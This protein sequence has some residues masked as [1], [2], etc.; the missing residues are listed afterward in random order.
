[1]RDERLEVS[2]TF[3]ERRGYVGSP[4]KVSHRLADE[5]E[6]GSELRSMP[7]FTA[8]QTQMVVQQ[9]QQVQPGSWQLV[10]PLG[11]RREFFQAGG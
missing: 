9:Q 10:R 2:V 8:E 7:P 1:M 11:R 3:D 5:L 4:R 6:Q